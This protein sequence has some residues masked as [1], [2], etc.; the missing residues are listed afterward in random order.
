MRIR[1]IGIVGAGTMGAGIG[2][3]AVSAGIPVVLLDVPATDGDP[4]APAKK[5][6]ER[7]LKARPAA[8]MDT[9]R[10]ALL[11][12]GNTRDDLGLLAECDLIVEAIIEKLEPKR[13]LYGRLEK[14]IN[15]ETIVA[16]NTSGIPMRALI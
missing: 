9:D 8:F 6:V 16:S 4:S 13:E 15:S 5:G 12:I 14:V 10:A 3:L 7:A 1:R 11:R 2:A